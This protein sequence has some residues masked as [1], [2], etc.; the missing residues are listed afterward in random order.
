VLHIDVKQSSSAIIVTCPAAFVH[1]F[2]E[3]TVGSCVPDKEVNRH[4]T[5]IIRRLLTKKS[6]EKK[7]TEIAPPSFVGI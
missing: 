6:T 2:C 7:S 1:A 3:R 5:T 4:S